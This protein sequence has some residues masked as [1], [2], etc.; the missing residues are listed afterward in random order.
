ML[1]DLNLIMLTSLK[2]FVFIH[3]LECYRCF[4]VDI[5]R[6]GTT[7]TKNFSSSRTPHNLK[8]NLP[9]AWGPLIRG[10]GLIKLTKCHIL[11]LLLNRTVPLPWNKSENHSDYEQV[12]P[13]S[14]PTPPTALPERWESKL[15]WRCEK[16]HFVFRTKGAK[17]KQ[18]ASVCSWS[19]LTR[20]WT[21]SRFRSSHTHELEV[22]VMKKICV[23]VRRSDL[24][25]DLRHF[26]KRSVIYCTCVRIL[27]P[28]YRVTHRPG[29]ISHTNLQVF[30]IHSKQSRTLLEIN[31]QTQWVTKD[32]STSIHKF[33]GSAET[34]MKVMR[35]CDVISC[36]RTWH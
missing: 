24:A 27:F 32:L 2:I 7:L 8:H 5:G 29:G 33:H 17:E 18:N 3:Y 16:T 26:Q 31:N 20:N 6:I 36:F 28:W 23:Y 30:K 1:I 10:E 21:E 9:E 12:W 35:H 4:L 34:I 13:G 15:L 14:E 25:E 11:S 19:Q 22:C